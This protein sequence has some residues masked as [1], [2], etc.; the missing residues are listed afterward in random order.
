MLTKELKDR[1]ESIIEIHDLDLAIVDKLARKDANI[2]RPIKGAGFEIYFQKILRANIP[3]IE[4][5]PGIGDSD[6]D[7]SINQIKLQLKTID[8]GST[9]TEVTVGVAL[10]KTHGNERRPHNLYS[11]TDPTFDLL[12]V[13]HPK[14]GIMLVP[15][16]EIPKNENYD[17][18]LADP[19]K[20]KWENNWLN[21]W[22]L[23]GFPELKGINIDPRNIPEKSL[24]P[25]ISQQ[26]FLD[27]YEIIEM[28]CRPEYFRAA[29]MG[30]KGNIKELWFI[31]HLEERGIKPIDPE[32]NYPKYDVAFKNKNNELKKIQ[33]KGTSK[34]MCNLEEK[35][36]GVEVMGTHG[37]FPSRG[38]TKSMF[39]Y[40]AVIISEKQLPK[41]YKG[42]GLHF[43]IIPMN[44]LPLH[45]QIGNVDARLEWG[46][47]QYQQVIY[48]NIK[49]I[50]K[51]DAKKANLAFYPDLSGYRKTGGKETIPAGS[52]FIKAGPYYLDE[53][54]F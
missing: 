6:I 22:D 40:A 4:I 21:R 48:P 41:E 15:Y 26:T 5:K 12:V 36:I 50:F 30:L 2:L 54:N 17:A 11:R 8:S 51:Y 16:D 53:L 10:H 7:L 19:A 24:L 37:Q 18:Y 23:I 20:F 34:N 14:Q 44:D 29:V 25:F 9:K 39:D 28:F 31:N 3:D 45:Y 43:I 33:V 47:P 32:G 13:L 52:S 27:D 42:S 46:L 49:L 1:F 38:Y 35:K